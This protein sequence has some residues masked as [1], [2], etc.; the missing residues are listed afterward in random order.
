MTWYAGIGA[1]ARDST[2]ALVEGRCEKVRRSSCLEAEAWALRLGAKMAK[3]EGYRKVVFET[4][5]GILHKELV[6]KHG[7]PSWHLKTVVEDVG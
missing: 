6:K 2:G 7:Q 4:D 3:E 1:I 5:S